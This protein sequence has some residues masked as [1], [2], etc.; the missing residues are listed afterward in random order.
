MST[1]SSAFEPTTLIDLLRW[2][3]DQQPEQR[4]YSFL[5]D[6]EAEKEFLTFA[7]LDLQARIISATLQEYG[8]RGDR[9]LLIYPS[10]LEFVTA[11]FG[12]LYSGIIA[13]PVYPPSAT[14]SDRTL[15]RFR[16]IAQNAQPTFILTTTTLATRVE[17]LL[18]QSPELAGVRV[19]VTD[20]LPAGN[21]DL[22]RDPGVSSDSLAFLQYTSG[23]TGAP[24][25]VMVTHAN[26][27][28]NSALVKRYCQHPEG[29]AHTVTWLPLYH[30]LGLIGGVLQPLY[31]G[32]ESTILSPASFLQ[33][34]IRWLQAVSRYRAT[35]SG[36]PNFAYDLCVRKITEEQ[37][38]TLDLS[39]WEVAANGAEP[40][41]AETLERFA[42]AFA[43]CGFRRE[44]FVP[45]YG[46]AE[47]TL[48][49]SAGE[50]LSFP[51]IW[52]FKARELE[53]N[54]AVEA[55]PG[56]EA[57]QQVSCGH[58]FED[59]L[60][61]AIV[62]PD[63]LRQCSD[64]HIGEIWIKGSSVAQGYWGRPEETQKTFQ[65][66]IADTGAGPF[67]RT[68]DLG[69]FYNGHLFIAGR[70][71]DLIIIRGSNHYPQ[72]IEETV[73]KCHPAVHGGAGSGAVFSVEIDGE[74]RLVVVQEV[75][76]SYLRSDLTEVV[77]AIRQAVAEQHELQT[78][79][80]I[81]LKTSS[82]HKTSSGKVQRHSVKQSFLAGELDAVCEWRLDLSD[83]STPVTMPETANTEESGAAAGPGV[84]AI[85]S[86]LVAHL[87]SL[88]K[89]NPRSVDVYAPFVSYGLDS[90][91]AVGVAGDLEMWLGRDLGPTLVYDYPTIH[92]LARYLAGEQVQEAWQD[93]PHPVTD[94][95]IAIVGLGC[96]FPGAGDPAAF[97]RML[98]DGK[99][100]I[101][102][103]PAQR[104]DVQ[105][106]YD[107]DQAV[108]G[109]MN[110]R[111]GGFLDQVDQFDPYFFAISPREAERMDPQQRLLLEVSWE[112]LEDAGVAPPAI[113]GSQT[114]VFVGI[115]ST[116]YAQLQFND[117]TSI[118]AYSGTGNAHSI[119]ANRLSY[120][121]DLRGPSIAVDTACS[122]ALVAL[123][124]ACQSLR[125]GECDMALAGGVNVLLSPDLTVAFSQARMM[126]SDGRCKTFDEAADGYVR[127]EGCGIVVL[128]PLSTAL[129]DNDRV[130]AVIRG[131][132]VNQDGRSNG[133]TAPNGLAQ[134]AVIR[135]ALH[136]AGVTPEQISYVETHGSS[137]PLGDPIEVGSLKNVLMQQRASDQSCVL[138]AVKSNIGHLEAAA[139]VA[140][141]IKTVLSLYHDEIPP[142]LHFNKLNPHISLEGT[143][144]VIPTACM[145]W[146]QRE[147]RLAGVSAF[148][149]GGTNAHVV[150]E[151]APRHEEHV[152]EMERPLHLL[153]L[154]A[155]SSSALQ[156]LARRYEDFR[157]LEPE[158]SDST[159]AD[160]CFTANTGRT[161]FQHRLAV[162]AGSIAQLRERLSAFAAG[163]R[164]ADTAVG[165]AQERG[166][167]GIAFLFTGQGSQYAGMARQVYETQPVFREA[168]KRCDQLLRPYLE[169]PLLSV[170][171][172]E[173]DEAARLLD[174]TAYT[175]PVLFA[176][177]YALAELWRSW[178]IEPD[179]VMGH[180]VGEY[181]AACVAGIFSLEDGL[182]LIAARARLMQAL[183]ERGT[184]LVVFAEPERVAAEL[185][186]F[187]EAVSIAAVNGPRNT[188]ISGKSE[189]IQALAQRFEQAGL[190]THPMTVS[191]AFHSPLMEPMLEE[192]E[193]IAAQ[194]HFAP[195]RIPLIRN[196]DGQVLQAGETLAADYWR[197]QIRAAVQFSASMHTAAQLGAG[198]FIE[199]GPHAV[200]SGMGKRCLPDANVAWL[201]S[202]RKDRADWQVLLQSVAALYVGGVPVNWHGFDKD[203]IRRKVALPTYPFE[204]ERY[205][206][207]LGKP[208]Q[209]AR[210]AARRL[211]VGNGH[212]HPLLSE[213]VEL[214][215]PAGTHVWEVD[216]DKQRL[217]YLSDHRIQ[218]ALA[219]PVSVY[220]EMAQA[221]SAEAFGAGTHTLAELDLKKLLLLPERGAQKVQVVLSTAENK[222]VHFHVYS[223]SAG[224]PE[225]PRNQWTLHASGK[226]RLN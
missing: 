223:H 81:L 66:F 206:F 14:R 35:L 126:S 179:M 209:T 10:G 98:R 45:C 87:A 33:R 18:A 34:P 25:G 32:F 88:L 118:D 24:K 213:H 27:F 55:A 42:E 226:I 21:G 197:G 82:M 219:V 153:T 19:I 91:Q 207:E 205:W 169:Q 155:R 150:L 123:H 64:G 151:A 78:Y 157:Y 5:A 187:R 65:A 8:R 121:L 175:Q 107:H 198:I 70:L 3:A 111:W 84:E 95:P 134:E 7:Q 204:R 102:E 60:Q 106:L 38:E 186:P 164:V 143:T 144:F 50:R 178:G 166:R 120:L 69:F 58:P 154:S 174:E 131:S 29:R 119:A 196:L 116:D 11:F 49:I 181:A 61:A 177:E 100:G 176:L 147:R 99:D 40:V 43:S 135:R 46:M 127:S 158:E 129:R 190:T 62:D 180:S 68:G 96:R 22:W 122:S 218:G 73:E 156:Q 67:L 139:G 133:L 103:V 23:S 216:L 114:G 101:S 220:I 170:L 141:L 77:A 211:S 48:V 185:E 163:Q 2:R 56:D 132:A 140:G 184:M 13:V 161:H 20:E 47:A 80:V 200:L 15:T 52:S 86:W 31:A 112:A 53:H 26:L 208:Q 28:H 71:K 93:R 149:F 16:S 92:T 193:R 188:V 30:D 146:P 113:A 152:S 115:S 83:I 165:Q 191:H 167:P 168:L 212:Y 183:P 194:V 97:W 89:V 138:G 148:G 195:A 51:G 128:K 162:S 225:Q 199:L 75:S 125:T 41:R 110:T 130:L 210:P 1:Y 189:A 142:N 17:G 104:W 74:E 63:T 109:K 105:A 59:E 44:A 159:L 54:Q 37:K 217:P 124:Q 171:Y 94:E 57:N 221:A 39:S 192:F 36:G 90:A 85:Q 9:A 202:L 136:N 160:I 203:Y 182:K 224:M 201:P 6:G 173:N 117:L 172:S 12:C 76:R 215:Y 137:T 214:A 145:P 4:I 79:A 222:S 108:P 72:D